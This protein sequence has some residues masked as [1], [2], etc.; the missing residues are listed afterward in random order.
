MTPD[1]VA[2]MRPN[3]S[4][5]A[6]AAIRVWNAC[7]GYYPERIPAVVALLDVDHVDGLLERMQAIRIG[8]KELNE[9]QGH[10]EHS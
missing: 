7:D 8:M 3:L 6:E 2:Q 10:D 1:A 9:H 4:D 5:E